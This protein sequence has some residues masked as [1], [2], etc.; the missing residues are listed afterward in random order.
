[1]CCSLATMTYGYHGGLNYEQKKLW[2]KA[3]GFQQLGALPLL[4]A[5]NCR[6]PLPGYLAILGT[7]LFSVPLYYSS[8][9][10]D[11]TFNK[12]MPYGGFIMMASWITLALL[13]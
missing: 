1:M 4:L 2:N 8:V 5:K 7:S 10:E 3:V 6:S 12:V 11:K 9:T 13:Q